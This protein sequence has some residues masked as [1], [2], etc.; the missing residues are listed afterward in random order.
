MIATKASSY[1]GLDY[2]EKFIALAEARNIR[3]A[4]FVVQS[5]VDFEYQDSPRPDII[6][7]FAS[8][9]HL[10]PEENTLVLQRAQQSLSD[11]G[12]LYISLKSADACFAA[13][14]QDEYGE[15]LFYY[16]H[17]DDIV[18]IAGDGFLEV[19]RDFQHIG[20]TEWFTLAL[21]KG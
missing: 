20:S 19:Y 16:Y 4:R 10:S 17:P 13:V 6:F 1:L 18:R 14:K 9:L 5:M 15:R 3:A 21:Q 12:I 7:A 11:S 2:A 8:L